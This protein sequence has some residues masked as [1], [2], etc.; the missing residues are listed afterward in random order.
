MIKKFK[1][2]V[3]ESKKKPTGFEEHDEAHA[4]IKKHAKGV[5]VE[6]AS[7][8]HESDPDH[9]HLSAVHP[10]HIDLL[11]HSLKAAGFH[12]HSSDSA[13]YHGTGTGDHGPYHH[14]SKGDTHVH[15][16]A[17]PNTWGKKAEEGHDHHHVEVHT[18]K[19]GDL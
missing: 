14:Y 9:V 13:P 3:A 4:I 16:S 5:A 17:K 1:E 12:H 11:H 15:I 2:F 10:K 19:A 6:H 7:G 8:D 18:S